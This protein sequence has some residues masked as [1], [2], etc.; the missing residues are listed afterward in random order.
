MK[1]RGLTIILI[2]LMTLVL[3]EP[4][5]AKTL[6]VDNR[7]KDKQYPERLNLR[8]EPSAQGDLIGLYYSGTAV[9]ELEAAEN[10][11]VKVEIAGVTG[12]MSG[13]Y[14]ITEEN[15][16]RTYGDG[17]EFFDGRIAQ[18][19]LSGMWMNRLP[20][21]S[22]PGGKGDQVTR[23]VNGAYVRLKGITADDWA[24]VAV[25]VAQEVR[26]GYVQLDALTDTDENKALVIAG[27]KADSRLILYSWPST[28]A[29]ELMSLKNGTACF[30]L[31]GRSVGGWR[32]VRVGGVSGWIREL[33]NPGFKLLSDTPRGAIPYYPLQ[34]QTKKETLLYSVPGDTG[35]IYMTLGRGM[36]VEVLAESEE[37]AYVRTF[38][39]GAG[40]YEHGDYGYIALSELSLAEVGSFVALA[41]VDD[42]DLPAVMLAQPDPQA[43]MI[44]ALCAG[45]QVRVTDFTQTN[46]MQ[47]ALGSGEKPVVGYVLKSALH[48]L[49]GADGELSQRIPQRATLICSSRLTDSDGKTAILDEKKSS[50][51]AGDRVYMFGVIGAKAYVRAAGDPVLDLADDTKDNTGFIELGS[52]NAPA[53]TTHLTAFVNTDKVNLRKEGSASAGI[54][55]KIR[56]GQRL[57]V[58]DYGTEWTCVVTPEGKRGYLMTKYLDFEQL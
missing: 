22:L 34:M 54:V 14:L 21:Y 48:L 26:L 5:C 25:T 13:E 36:E 18:V 19:D 10:G 47:V 1:K 57:R 11:Y 4:A 58:A 12:Y 55:G 46:Y 37:Y 7:E 51:S 44:G 39:G 23:L 2:V 52:L 9:K 17:H 38:E 27:D 30:N 28:K 6:Y 50:L 41:Q 42:G 8:A 40:T 32:K 49:T 15:A 20:V 16:M 31:F 33:Y 3:S 53:S 24:Y 56:L 45:A 35:S 43:E 29:K